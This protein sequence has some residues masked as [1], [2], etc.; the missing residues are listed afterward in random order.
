MGG[1][2]ALLL[3]RRL[4]DRAPE[5]AAR[6]AGLVLIAP[7]WDMTEELMWKQFPLE[8]RARARGDAA[9]SVQPSEYGEPYAITRALIEEGRSH[10]L[11][12][13]AV[14]P[15]PARSS[16]CRGASTRPCRS[17][18][19]ASLLGFLQGGWAQLIEIPDGEHR[20]SRPQDLALL[21][22]KIDEL[23]ERVAY[24]PA[25]ERH[26]QRA[27]SVESWRL[28]FRE[29]EFRHETQRASSSSPPPA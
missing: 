23:A 3:L 5:E 19:R 16:S 6:I 14:R 12:R 20:L 4:M 10:L 17:A 18:T 29:S 13:A 22:T 11:A 1:Y 9:S 25:T 27:A 26:R 15:G 24:R 21:F 28:A 2:I 7:A 8:A